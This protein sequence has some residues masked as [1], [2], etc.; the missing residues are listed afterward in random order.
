[1]SLFILVDTQIT[2]EEYKVHA[3]FYMATMAFATVLINGSTAKYLLRA[4]GLLKMT[5]E[6][7][8]VLEHVLSVRSTHYLDWL[9][10][11]K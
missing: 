11:C 9:L 10:C 4:L 3:L 2:S 7:M 1:M 6:Q 5:P 8:Q